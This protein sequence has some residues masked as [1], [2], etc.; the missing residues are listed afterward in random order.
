MGK[1]DGDEA[2]DCETKGPVTKA[3]LSSDDERVQSIKR[4]LDQMLGS[5]LDHLKL[6]GET[7]HMISALAI[8]AF[9]WECGQRSDQIPPVVIKALVNMA[10]DLGIAEQIGMVQ[11]PGPEE[12]I[13]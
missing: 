8:T 2:E 3:M 9:V 12:T 7:R 1:R 6:E 4:G 5:M 13:N 11:M 10:V